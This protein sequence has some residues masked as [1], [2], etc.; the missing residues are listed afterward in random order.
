LD[1]S[2]NESLLVTEFRVLQTH[3][4]DNE[5]GEWVPD[6]YS[7]CVTLR[8]KNPESMR[9]LGICNLLESTFGFECILDFA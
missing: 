1:I 5:K 9:E 3:S 4:Y 2:Y 6:S 7:I 8:D